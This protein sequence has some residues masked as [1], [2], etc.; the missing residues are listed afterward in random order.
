MDIMTREEYKGMAR[1]LRLNKSRYRFASFSNQT[2][3]IPSMAETV[4][5]LQVE[6]NQRKEIS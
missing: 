2:V 3:F 4:Y 6:A 1:R 5:Q